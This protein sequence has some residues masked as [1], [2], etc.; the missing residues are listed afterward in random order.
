VTLPPSSNVCS[1]ASTQAVWQQI[2]PH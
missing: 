2:C 1:S